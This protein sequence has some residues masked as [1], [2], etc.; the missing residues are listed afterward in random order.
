MEVLKSIIYGIVEGI[1]EWLPISSTGHMILL[2]EIMP[3]NVSPEFWDMYLEVIQLGA[4]MAVVILFWHRIWPFGKNNDHPVRETGILS[5]FRKDVWQM[6]FKMI[7]SCIPAVM[8]VV[9]HLDDKCNELFYNAPCV[10]AA[11]IVFGV[12]FIVVETLHTGKQAKVRKMS[13][14]TYPMALI[15]GVFQLIAAIFPGTSRSGATI[16]GA[17]MIGISRTAAAEYTFIM[18]VPVMMGA[19]LKSLVKFG[20]MTGTEAVIL[21][22]GMIAA[23]AVSVA[24]IKFL[25]GY[26]RKHDFKIFG[27]Y[28]IALGVIV[29]VFSSFL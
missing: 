19:S 29:L 17:L 18:A 26:I 22:T 6:W 3:L 14:I 24:V 16:I 8:L 2:K 13:G 10:A 15:I 11:L 4:I 27:W 9:L 25:M 21:I 20:A 12:M 5:W 28:R 23:F 7:V 1:T